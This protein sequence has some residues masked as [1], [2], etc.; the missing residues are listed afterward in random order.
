MTRGSVLYSPRLMDRFF[1]S[2][3]GV[4][5][6]VQIS[7]DSDVRVAVLATKLF[8]RCW[9]SSEAMIAR[10]SS[11]FDGP[12]LDMHRFGSLKGPR[13]HADVGHFLA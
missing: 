7:S 1:S 12:V 9:S 8:I 13:R 11:G 5:G 6:Y 2:S 4:L 10:C 3:G